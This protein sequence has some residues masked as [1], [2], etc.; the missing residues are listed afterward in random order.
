MVYTAVRVRRTGLHGQRPAQPSWAISASWRFLGGLL[1]GCGSR[2]RNHT[3]RDPRATTAERRTVSAFLVGSAARR[4]WTRSM[5]SS[6][7]SS[8]IAVTS[9][10]PYSLLAKCSH[11]AF[12]WRLDWNSEDRRH[13]LAVHSRSEQ[14][15]IRD[16]SEPFR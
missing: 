7:P 4:A 2:R 14:E 8:R 1:L 5:V 10:V 13:N 9:A 3:A 15:D 11:C 6:R 12:N 16:N